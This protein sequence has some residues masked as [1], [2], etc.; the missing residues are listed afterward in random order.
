MVKLEENG[1]TILCSETE[2]F[3][4][5]CSLSRAT[6][7]NKHNVQAF[8]KNVR[9]VYKKY[10]LIPESI[11]NCDETG[12]STV[13]DPP[14]V[15]AKCGT[16]QVVEITLGERGAFVTMLAFINAISN[17]VLPVFIFPRVHFKDFML[18]SAP[19]GSLGL[20]KKSG[21]ITED[22]FYKSLQHFTHYTKSSQEN[23]VLLLFDN[24]NTQ[25]SIQSIKFA[26]EK[27]IIMLTFPPHTSHHLQPLDVSVY[28]LFKT[29]FKAEHNKWLINPG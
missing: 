15:I 29:R 27:G 24:P 22:N 19:F 1:C 28:D 25:V 7:F 6:A 26:R 17:T 10:K 14:K 11:Y 23:Q 2:I 4:E 16:K 13:T 9:E 5:A 20:S 21:W 8:Y 18:N 12:L 3:L